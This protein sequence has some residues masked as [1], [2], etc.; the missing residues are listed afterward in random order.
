MAID[1]ESRGKVRTLL[2]CL[3]AV[4]AACNIVLLSATFP[5][6]A[7]VIPVLNV[8]TG[9]LCVASFSL[10]VCLGG[11]VAARADSRQG[12]VAY[13]A[14][15]L[16]VLVF[17][18]Y[19]AILCFVE[20][21]AAPLGPGSSPHTLAGLCVVVCLLASFT[22]AVAASL[23]GRAWT[24]QRVGALSSF[25]S[26]LAA[27]A[28]AGF[29]SSTE[30]SSLV[31]TAS[32]FEII[33]SAAGIPIFWFGWSRLVRLHGAWSALSI[34]LL[35]VGAAAALSSDRDAFDLCKKDPSTCKPRQMLALAALAA[36]TC[37]TSC[38]DGT[39]SAIL[40]AKDWS[41]EKKLSF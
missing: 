1:P 8:N 27:C 39:C 15:S 16:V 29:A 2:A 25:A 3:N 26:L 19:A 38:A 14:C 28:L 12:Y 32:V 5:H 13:V 10:A 20:P 41:R 35:M 34:V 6:V 17:Y 37:V 24:A 22:V 23:G 33:D 36:I 31:V 18:V 40:V 30:A 4:A 7:A 21:D 11:M 9:V